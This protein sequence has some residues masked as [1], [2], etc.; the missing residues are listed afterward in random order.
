MIFF[1]KCMSSTNL[2]TCR[3]PVETFK[4]KGFWA[5][6]NHVLITMQLCLG[7][8]INKH[9]FY[10]EEEMTSK[11]MDLVYLVICSSCN[12]GYILDT[13]KDK[14]RARDNGRV[15]Q[16]IC[17]TQNWKLKYEEN[18][19]IYGKGL[20]KGLPFINLHLNNK[21]TILRTFLW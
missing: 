11:S 21:G 4:W 7:H 2:P 15:Y 18:F 5:L 1:Q 16:R 14:T 20:F 17:Q 8:F 3:N 10:P 9:I 12:K 6:G 19:R 13:R